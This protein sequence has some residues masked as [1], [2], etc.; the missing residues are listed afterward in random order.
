MSDALFPE[1]PGHV[2]TPGARR[3]ARQS[4]AVRHRRHPLSVALGYDIPLHS[5]A[6]EPDGP[7]CGGCRFRV[8]VPGG[9]RSFPKC[10]AGGGGQGWPR[11]THGAATDVLASWPACIDYQPKEPR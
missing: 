9:D 8:Q 10:S 4:V 2:P 3:R 6:T 5:D 1:P 11:A 7:R